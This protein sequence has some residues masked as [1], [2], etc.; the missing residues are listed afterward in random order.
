[1]KKREPACRRCKKPIRIQQTGRKKIYCSS[2]CRWQSR[3]GHSSVQKYGSGH[4]G[5]RI[6]RNDSDHAHLSRT[7]SIEN[8]GRA[9][10]R[11]PIERDLWQKIIALEIGLP[12]ATLGKFVI[13]NRRTGKLSFGDQPTCLEAANDNVDLGQIILSAGAR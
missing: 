11:K 12:Q 10:S 6:A 4:R 5:S 7:S 8:G 2:K 3:P 9:S 1:M 13:L